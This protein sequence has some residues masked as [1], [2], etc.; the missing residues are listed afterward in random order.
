MKIKINLAKIASTPPSSTLGFQVSYPT[1]VENVTPSLAQ[2][3]GLTFTRTTSLATI[4]VFV[5]GQ[6]VTLTGDGIKSLSAT[7]DYIVV[8]GTWNLD[9]GTTMND[10]LRLGY[11]SY[12]VDGKTAFITYLQSSD[13]DHVTKS[14]TEVGTILG[15]F[16][17]AIGL[18]RMD[19]DIEGYARGFNYVWIPT[20]GRYYYVD[21]V[22]MVTSG[23]TRLHLKEDVLMSWASLIMR[24]TAYIERQE[25][26][27]DDDLID[28]RASY[29]YAKSISISAITMTN[30]IFANVSN[31][32]RDFV[33]ETVGGN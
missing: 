22:E 14:L 2:F 5:G 6:S 26:S 8:E 21:S 7:G 4:E 25:I 28:E 33:I 29:A 27:Y 30:D 11:I 13:N 24:Q 20:L 15:K 32:D 18:R 31:N 23:I 12:D 3:V 17:K 16:S 10:L 1:Y 9:S 19:V